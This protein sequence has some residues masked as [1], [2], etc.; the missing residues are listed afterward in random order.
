MARSDVLV[1]TAAGT[2][3][4]MHKAATSYVVKTNAQ[5]LY[6]VYVDTNN[7]VVFKKSTDGGIEWS[8][9]T[10]IFAGTVTYLSVWYDRW[11]NIAAGLIHIAYTES[12]G[13]D[14]LYRTIN[15]ENAD[16]LSTET[17]IFAGASQ[18][19]G[20]SLSI[21]RS[22]G[23]N[24]YCR[25][26]I[27]AGVEGGF[28][29]LLNANVPNGAWDAARTVNETL[30]TTDQM[31]LV[32]G[33]AADTNDIFGF[34][35]D[36]SAEEISRQNYD[37]SANSWAETSIATSMTDQ[38]ASTAFPHYAASVDITN[39]RNLLVAWSNV[40]TLNADLRCWYVTDAAI[41]EVTNVVLNS[42]DD[43]GLC[44]IGIDT[45]T[46]DWYVFYTGK[47][48]GSQ[49]YPTSTHLYY[50]QS[51]DDGTTWG[52]ETVLSNSLR[53]RRTLHVTPRFPT[54][55]VCM[56]CD[57]TINEYLANVV[58]PAA[59]AAGGSHVVGPTMVVQ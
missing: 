52:S 42:T 57:D 10:V 22:R 16:A 37:D 14:T 43:Q 50:K 5:G 25:T 7:D 46:E 24:V 55:F 19:T 48:D 41:T 53:E 13:S 39:S 23:G 51:T 2:V 27:D 12:G 11:S 3:V 33:W 54:A 1:A 4:T 9:F 45:A 35:W 8:A 59:G 29:R 38:L 34:F 47:S 15:V 28:F 30:A 32:P 20:G 26:C 40:D 18:A 58:T 44:G 21:T 56:T 49:T 36:A 6:Y 31:I 17:T